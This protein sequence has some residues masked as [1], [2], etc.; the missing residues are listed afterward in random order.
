M[1]IPLLDALEIQGK[2][3][4]ADAL[5][6]QRQLATYLVEQRHAHYYFTVKANQPGLL[7]DLPFYFRECG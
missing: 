4:A 5:L 1:A 3:I 7:E 2:E 6:T